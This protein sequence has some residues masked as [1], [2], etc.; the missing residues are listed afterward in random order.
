MSTIEQTAQAFVNG[1]S[2]HC[3]NAHTDGQ[4][5]T[6]HRT[7]IVYR[8]E[9]GQLVTDWGG[10]YTKTTASHMNAVLKAFGSAR[11]VSYA[12][13]RDSNEGKVTHTAWA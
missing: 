10:F 5:Y 11:R 4:R 2:A 13:A 3:H 6:L 9:Q 1:K 8:N 12:K 7:I